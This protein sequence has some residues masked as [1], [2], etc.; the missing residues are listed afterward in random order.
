[1][2]TTEIDLLQGLPGESL[3]RQ[4]L[5]DFGS[6]HCT[7]EALLVAMAHPRL[8]RA[9]LVSG[10]TSTVFADPEIKLYRLLQQRGGDSYS[11]Y[12][13]LVRELVSFEHA[14]DHRLR[15]LG[16]RS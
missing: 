4:G 6:G 1:M 11:A 16:T 8:A 9:G 13:A 7:A 14:L 5:A 15:R 2:K 10:S 12:N 3:L